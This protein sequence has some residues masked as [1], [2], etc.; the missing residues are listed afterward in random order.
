MEKEEEQLGGSG[1]T[2]GFG[3]GG[4]VGF[5]VGAGVCFGVGGVVGFVVGAGV[6]FDLLTIVIQIDHN[7]NR[8]KKRTKMK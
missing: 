1:G 7:K 4:V 2:V 8:K 3:V 6:G 5:D